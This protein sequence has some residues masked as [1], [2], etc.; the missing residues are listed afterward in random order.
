MNGIRG[1]NLGNWLVL[2]K[3]M[4]PTPFEGSDAEDETW[5]ARSTPRLDLERILAK[6][7]N[8]YVLE[9]DFERLAQLSINL[10]RIPVPYFLFGD[11]PPHVG[12]VEHLDRAFDWAGRHGIKVL[13]DLHTVPGGQNGFDNGGITGVCKW[14]KDPA[15][16]EFVLTVLERIALRYGMRDE[17]FGIEVLNEPIS[18][19]TYA[20][21]SSTGTAVDTEEAKGSAFVPMAFLRHFYT[22]AYQRLRPIMGPSKAIVFHDGFR[23]RRWKRFFHETR[24]ENVLLDTHV[25]LSSVESHLPLAHPLAY[26]AFLL[27]RRRAIAR[28]QRDV[29]VFVGEWCICCKYADRA[30]RGPEQDR[31]YRLI[32]RIELDAWSNT[33]GWIYWNYQL[34]RDRKTPYPQSWKESWDFCRCLQ[35]GWLTQE[36]FDQAAPH[37]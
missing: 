5:L 33:A 20:T 26:K 22:Q 16:V 7:R 34:S 10:V 23:I 19:F 6:H 28:I 24:M 13:V 32:S 31:R 30:G 1:V 15:E 17:L 3:W 14:H 11:R 25:Y 12:C 18:W 2:E 35:N 37:R 36:M 21:A 29:P 9:Q 8:S 27:A 4:D